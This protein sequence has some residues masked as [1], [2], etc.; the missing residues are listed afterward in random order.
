MLR[1]A[2]SPPYGERRQSHSVLNARPSSGNHVFSG[3]GKRRNKQPQGIPLFAGRLRQWGEE[4]VRGGMLGSRRWASAKNVENRSGVEEGATRW[5]Q[6][7]NSGSSVGC[8]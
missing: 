8:P 1:V 7:G 3:W 5:I 6:L 2:H 4:S